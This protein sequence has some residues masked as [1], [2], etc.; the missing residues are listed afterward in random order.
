MWTGVGH[1]VRNN[2]KVRSRYNLNA[3]PMDSMVLFLTQLKAGTPFDITCHIF[4]MDMQIFR[5]NFKSFAH[6]LA[7][8]LFDK[9]R[10][11]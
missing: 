9:F 7:K 1:I 8:D 5:H 3:H 4:S 6:K 2:M 11:H 10:H